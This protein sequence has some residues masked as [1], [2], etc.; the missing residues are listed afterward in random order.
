MRKFWFFTALFVI[1]SLV[2]S[3]C[4]F[5]GLPSLQ[6]G[7]QTPLEDAPMET[8]RALL[9]VQPVAGHLSKTLA[10]S[11]SRAF[12]FIPQV[13][14][15]IYHP[16]YLDT[17]FRTYSFELPVAGT[18]G[19]RELPLD[20]PVGEN[21][22]IIVDINN[23]NQAGE[24]KNTV[25]GELNGVTVVPNPTSD[26]KVNF[27]RI[28]CFPVSP[29]LVEDGYSNVQ[30][31]IATSIYSI[32][33]DE[34]TAIGGEIWL[35]FI[36]TSSVK[37]LNLI[38]T[39]SD[40][41]I[42]AAVFDQFGKFLYSNL[43]STFFGGTEAELVLDMG[44]T[45]GET[46][47][48]GVIPIVT[49]GSTTTEDII[50]VQYGESLLTDDAYEHHY[51][52]YSS[53]IENDSFEGAYPL[54]SIPYAGWVLPGGAVAL[55]RDRYRFTY[56]YYDSNLLYITIPDVQLIEDPDWGYVLGD[57][58][59]LYS[60]TR[61]PIVELVSWD[62]HWNFLDQ[63]FLH[64]MIDSFPEYSSYDPQTATLTIAVPIGYENVVGI[65]VCERHPEQGFYIPP[66]VPYSMVFGTR[67]DAGAIIGVD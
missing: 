33:L 36:A 47:F 18:G 39:A 9:M 66:N 55:D 31:S 2:L 12:L 40:S 56:S 42:Y 23:P 13:V 43:S 10:V 22:R 57:G 32:E 3:A 4:S 1:V 51:D 20:L 29:L 60:Y 35:Q 19:Q 41:H 53:Y 62:Y 64:P 16:A 26:P 7:K 34:F 28:T 17:P 8:G 58:G 25:R 21:W 50:T 24:S 27:F 5:G 59:L 54:G 46:Y 6:D 30:D 38:P 44:V 37:A 52:Y 11:S 67:E 65:D 61:E 14:V 48:L 15:S 49:T 45:P 63:I